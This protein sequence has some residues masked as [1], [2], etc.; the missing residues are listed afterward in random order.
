M[1][2]WILGASIQSGLGGNKKITLGL[3]RVG[4]GSINS[5]PKLLVIL[6]KIKYLWNNEFQLRRMKLKGVPE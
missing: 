4:V 2:A 1:Q 3:G 5:F 6:V